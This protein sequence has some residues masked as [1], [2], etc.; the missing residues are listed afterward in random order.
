MLPE[1]YHKGVVPMKFFIPMGVTLNTAMEKG[2][3]IPRNFLGKLEGTRPLTVEEA[4]AWE[5]YLKAESWKTEI[6][7]KMAV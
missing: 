1:K 4:S 7:R 6:T 2:W 5:D 3:V